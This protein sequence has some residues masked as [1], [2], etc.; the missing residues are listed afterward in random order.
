M[1]SILRGAATLYA[2]YSFIRLMSTKFEK[3]DAFKEG[4]IDEKGNGIKKGSDSLSWTRF[5]IL[6]RNIKQ[7]LEKIPF[8][9]KSSLTSFA[10]SL[11]LLKEETSCDYT[12]DLAEFL[13]IEY[14]NQ[15]TECEE[16]DLPKGIYMS[17]DRIVEL[18]E[19]R[20]GT[21]CGVSIYKVRDF[22]T[23]EKLVVSTAELG[24]V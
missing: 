5:H 13:D 9:G 11:W 22:I 8:I 14:D 24:E 10:S 3:W 20:I 7:L 18:S 1:P 4:I 2:S 23:H 16:A 15:I 6:I 19:S 17:N 21:M 12:K